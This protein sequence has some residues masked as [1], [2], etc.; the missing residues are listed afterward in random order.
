[1]VGHGVSS[2]GRRPS[3]AP[4]RVEALHDPAAVRPGTLVVPPAGVLADDPAPEGLGLDVARE[5]RDFPLPR[6]RVEQIASDLAADALT[7]MPAQDEEL[8]DIARAVP[9]EVGAV[10]DQGET[11]Q[12][13]IGTH[14]V[15]R[16]LRIR[17]EPLDDGGVAVE[18]LVADGPVVDR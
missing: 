17:P 6:K 9:G 14:Q 2:I 13:A 1:V 12:D 10:A 8:A 11:D 4:L 5:L 7:T 15:G 18:T 16:H 3:S